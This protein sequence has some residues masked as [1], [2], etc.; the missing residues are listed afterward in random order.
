M[1]L[2]RILKST[3]I[4]IALLVE[5]AIYAILLIILDRGIKKWQS[6]L[7]KKIDK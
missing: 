6:R 3:D 5:F 2:A 4:M 1:Y 7:F